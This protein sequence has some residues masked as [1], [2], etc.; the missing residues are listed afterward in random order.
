ML[1]AWINRIHSTR[2]ARRK[3][4]DG[5]KTHATTG[6]RHLDDSRSWRSLPRTGDPAS[7]ERVRFRATGDEVPCHARR[8]AFGLDDHQG[9]MRAS[10]DDYEF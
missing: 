8:E 6:Q 7:K 2:A 10:F 1:A 4:P 3:R 5:A 9:L